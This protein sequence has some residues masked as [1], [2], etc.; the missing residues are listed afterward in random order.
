M[1]TS[2]SLEQ[3]NISAVDSAASEHRISS[4][5]RGECAVRLDPLRDVLLVLFNACC[6]IGA[7]RR[8]AAARGAR[9]RSARFDVYH[10]LVEAEVAPAL[11]PHEDR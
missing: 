1:S 7:R 4:V 10:D 8:R 9:R 11:R 3:E 6:E 5:R 2:L